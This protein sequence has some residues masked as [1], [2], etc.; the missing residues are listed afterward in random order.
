MNLNEKKT[1]KYKILVALATCVLNSGYVITNN[2]YIIENSLMSVLKNVPKHSMMAGKAVNG[3]SRTQSTLTPTL[4]IRILP[5][6]W[7][8]FSSSDRDK[9]ISHFAQQV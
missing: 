6:T 7:A 2:M 4:G 5:A 9:F 8:T 3:W 1:R